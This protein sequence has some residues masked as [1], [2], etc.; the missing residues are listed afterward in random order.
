MHFLPIAERELRV[1]SRQGRTYWT[2]LAAGLV[3]I[4]AASYFFWVISAVAGVNSGRRVFDTLTH[5]AFLVCLFA[6]P[7]YTADCLSREK[8]DGTL[9]FLFLTNLRTYDIVIGKLAA[10]SVSVV[11]G[12]AATV[13]VFA[14][15]LVAGGVQ[16]G[17]FARIILSLLNTLFFSLAAGL[18]VSSWVWEERKAVQT[19]SGILLVFG[20]VLPLLGEYL[21]RKTPS[22]GLI[23]ILSALSPGLSLGLGTLPSSTKLYWMSLGVVH[24][25]AWVALAIACRVLRVSWQDRPISERAPWRERLHQWLLRRANPSAN[26]RPL[27]DANPFCWLVSRSRLV[28]WETWLLLGVAVLV[29]AWGGWITRGK[30]PVIIPCLMLAI[31]LHSIGKMQLCAAACDRLAEDKRSGALEMLLGTPIRISEMLRGQMLALIRQFWGVLTVVVALDFVMLFLV[32]AMPEPDGP[33]EPDQI[34]LLWLLLFAGV[35]LLVIDAAALGWVGMWHAVAASNIQQ[36]RSRTQLRILILPWVILIL[37]IS[38]TGIFRGRAVQPAQMLW[39][40]FGLGLV[41]SVLFTLDARRRLLGRLRL[42]AAERF[43]ST[44]PGQAWFAALTR[45]AGHPLPSGGRETG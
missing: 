6:G 33:F 31:G 30:I 19:T 20:F 13:P 25:L 8:R 10:T 2:R 32:L 24:L 36:A 9:G 23:P 42:L 7:K 22:A 1:A 44:P 17:E 40:W 4:V 43:Q 39:V 34:K 41:N 16:A 29:A 45:P 21:R 35:F 28:V 14:L 27:L 5:L 37:W 18:L 26:D 3:A 38:Y 12:L 15:C 11:Y